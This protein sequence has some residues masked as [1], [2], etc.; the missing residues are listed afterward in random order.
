MTA[1]VQGWLPRHL[2][3]RTGF[4]TTLEIRRSVVKKAAQLPYVGNQDSLPGAPA[5]LGGCA[6]RRRRA[7]L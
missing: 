7:Y 4:S 3:A 1:S 5:G 2:C 6:V